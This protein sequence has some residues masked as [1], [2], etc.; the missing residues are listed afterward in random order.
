MKVKSRA[1]FKLLDKLLL[2]SLKKETSIDAIS[3]DMPHI[4]VV[5][6]Y[7][8]LYQQ[9][10]ILRN[11]ESGSE[12]QENYGDRNVLS[13][14]SARELEQFISHETVGL[15]IFGACENHGDHMPFGS[16]FIMPFELAKR[17]AARYGKKIIIFPPIPYGVSSHH[18]DFF[19]TVSFEPDTMMNVIRDILQS[20]VNN[21]IRNILIINGHDGNIAPIELA[22][23]IIK[24]RNPR[25]V[26]SCLESWWTLVGSIDKELFDVWDG[27]G[28]GGE[29]ETSAMLAVRPD[30]VNMTVAPK[31]VIPKLPDNIRIYWKFNELTDTG[32]TGAP[33]KA[34]TTKGNKII[35]ILENVLLEFILDM[36]KDRWKYGIGGS[37]SNT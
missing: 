20:L 15:L 31:D 3:S 12:N 13:E 34:T 33:R 22:S 2:S 16:D 28:H 8:K 27:L 5:L 14:M 7:D 4:M 24:E 37:G 32:A 26:I 19:M 36:E 1:I 10:P 25:V 21:N 9:N 6:H 30:L 35:S 18:K 11:V 17:V 23:R 29:A